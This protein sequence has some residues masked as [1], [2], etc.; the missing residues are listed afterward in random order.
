METESIKILPIKVLLVEDNPGDARLIREMLPETSDVPFDLACVDRLSDGL[1]RMA[2]GDMD[3]V[4]LDLSLPDSQGLDTFIRARDHAPQMPIILLTG[5]DDKESAV[6][7]VREGAQD[8][9]VKG[10]V[11]GNLLVR[12]VQYAIERKQAERALVQAAQHWQNTFDAIEDMV[13]IIDRD[14]RVL[15]AN[16]AM[17][18]AFAGQEMIGA[19]CHE[20]F[21]GTEESLPECPTCQTFRTGEA[22][23]M[24]LHEEHLGDRWINMSAYPIREKD[25]AVQ[26]IVHVVRDITE[27]KLAEERIQ[28]QN[29]LTAVGRLAGGIAHDFNNL[30]T[31][32]IGYAELASETLDPGSRVYQ[33]IN[34]IP[35]LGVR[36]ADL[37][38]QLLT[39]SRQ[40]DVERKPMNLVPLIK[41]IVKMLERTLPES[42]DIRMVG[43]DQVAAINADPTQIQQVIMNLCVNA[44]HAMP[45]G[46]ELT[47]EIN[48][49]S[50]DREYCG[51]HPEAKPGDYIRLSVRDTGVGMTSDVQERAFEPFFTTKKVGE[52]TGLG[53]SV[54]YGIVRA[55]EGHIGIYSEVGK[56]TQ[57]NVYIPST[58]IEEACEEAPKEGHLPVGT[59]HLLFVEDEPMVLGAGRAMLESLGYTV[60]TAK[61]GEEG[62]K[63]YLAHWDEISLVLTDMVMPRMGGR[64]L[65]EALTRVNPEVKVVLVSG[66][67][68]NQSLDELMSA[69]FKGFVHKPFRA[70]NLA[71]AVREAL[72]G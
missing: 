71:R 26:Q 60:L 59:E 66:Y 49:V 47:L 35:K 14:Y 34:A 56:G 8:Y 19:H 36:G 52:G 57:F 7:A 23:H 3:V 54:V 48:S 12:A 6:T 46:G 42:I 69:G 53:L 65:H 58:S 40:A 17:S 62:L 9:L 43:M 72:D 28:R 38:K 27:Q 20:L 44:G 70:D 24:E 16:R 15:R 10:Q 45:E 64:D 13:A 32:I 2:S 30:L 41:E 51:H 1:E 4:L 18:E 50:L 39:F 61:D 33:Y 22:T 29:R 63:T 31:G 68:M 25:N 55:H 37:I 11:D 67:S 21:H 5:L